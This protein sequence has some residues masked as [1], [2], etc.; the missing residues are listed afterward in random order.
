MYINETAMKILKFTV[1]LL[2]ILIINSCKDTE[3]DEVE[4]EKEV[5]VNWKDLD[6]EEQNVRFT[7]MGTLYIGSGKISCRNELWLSFQDVSGNDLVEGIKFWGFD[8]GG[9][10]G[11]MVGPGGMVENELY[12]LEHVYPG[13]NTIRSLH[14]NKGKPFSKVF[15]ELNGKYD[16]LHFHSWPNYFEK[17]IIKLT[18][19]YV[20][21]DDTVHE[22]VTWWK[23]TERLGALCHRIEFG[24][25]E[26]TEITYI[27]DDFA[28]LTDDK[29]TW[30]IKAEN[31]RTYSVATL[32]LGR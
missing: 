24:D 26:I 30:V 17:I 7:L 21:G 5:M 19:P 25:N 11:F 13:H 10:S 2:T 27:Y 22:I 1:L 18:C 3:E 9:G 23:K 15:P 29:G 31:N 4:S 8:Y 32:V 28:T 20:F 14:L 16:Y 12:V 6:I